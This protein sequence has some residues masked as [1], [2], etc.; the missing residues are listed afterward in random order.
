MLGNFSGERVT[1]DL[2]GG[3]GREVVI[4]DAAGDLVLQPWEGRVHRRRRL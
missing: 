1:P 2:P 4:G 3:P